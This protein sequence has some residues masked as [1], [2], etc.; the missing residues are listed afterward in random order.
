MLG[1]GMMFT[2][3]ASLVL[4]DKF[5][6]KHFWSDCREYQCTVVQYIGE[7]CRY[8]CQAP[9]RS[10]DGNNHVRIAIGNGLRPEIWPTFQ[11]R[12]NIKEIGEFHGATEGNVSILNH[13]TTKAS[14]GTLGR[15]GFLL[16]KLTGMKLAKFDVV[17]EEVVRDASGFCIECP[18]GEAGEL[19]GFIK[20]DDPIAQFAGYHGNT[21]ATQKKSLLMLSKR[22]INISA[23]GICSRK[24]RRGTGISSIELVTLFDGR[25][26][27]FLQTRLLRLLLSILGSRTSIFM[28][29]KYPIMMEGHAWLPSSRARGSA[30]K[31]LPNT[32]FRTCPHTPYLCL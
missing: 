25:E 18:P 30:W 24:M 27:T 7:L 8:L 19:L 22:E 23:P 29:C 11:S 4:R 21:A 26:R 1:V 15:T 2:S 3:G 10:T 13:S 14:Q 31:A 20:D 28:V 9:P 32:V 16:Q 5:S 12:F 17:T 6:L